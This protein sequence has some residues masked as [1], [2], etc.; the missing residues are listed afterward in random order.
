MYW[1]IFSV[2]ISITGF[3]MYCDVKEI[4]FN[5]FGDAVKTIA[6]LAIAIAGIASYLLY[7]NDFFKEENT[8]VY[9]KFAYYIFIAL[10]V[11]V[12]LFSMLV[13]YLMKTHVT[14]QDIG[15]VSMI[16]LIF[17]SIYG[18]VTRKKSE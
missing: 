5:D 8:D 12:F 10:V 11:A 16:I 6:G 13:D 14:F 17:W 2:L 4:S 18:F 9:S 3:S 7:K 1:S 15:S